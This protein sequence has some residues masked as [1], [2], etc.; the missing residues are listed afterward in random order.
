MKKATFEEIDGAIGSYC[1][2]N[3]GGLAILEI[4]YGIEDHVI[5]VDPLEFKHRAK[6]YYTSRPYFMYGRMRIHFDECIR[7]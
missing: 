6:I 4:E 3:T 1:L 2:S 7:V 5:Y